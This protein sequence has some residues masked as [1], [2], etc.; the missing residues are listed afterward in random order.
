MSNKTICESLLPH[1]ASIFIGHLDEQIK[2]QESVP[3]CS[4]IMARVE[5]KDVVTKRCIGLIDNQIDEIVGQH[6]NQ[7]G[8]KNVEVVS[9]DTVIA[10]RLGSYHCLLLTA[11]K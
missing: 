9:K 5:Y 2:C 10:R 6:F 3:E 1:F 7:K 11:D 4:R 8:L